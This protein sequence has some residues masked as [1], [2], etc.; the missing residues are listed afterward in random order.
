M[1]SHGWNLE[2]AAMK[3]AE[4]PIPLDDCPVEDE[5]LEDLD[6]SPTKGQT[7]LTFANA[8]SRDIHVKVKPLQLLVK[9]NSRAKNLGV[10]VEAG[11]AGGISLEGGVGEAER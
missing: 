4:G 5:V 9:K 2:M 7:G 6:E 11:L 1:G 10:G 8:T 3:D